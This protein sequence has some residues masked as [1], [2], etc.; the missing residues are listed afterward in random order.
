[1]MLH[2]YLVRHGQTEWN[3]GGRF[4]GQS[5][6]KLSEIGRKQ[7]Q[8]LTKYFPAHQLQAIYASTLERA[9]ETAN[10][11]AERYHA[12]VHLRDDLREMNFGDWEGLTFDEISKDWQNGGNEF[13]E[14]PEALMPPHGETFMEG[15]K[16]GIKALQDIMQ[17]HTGEMEEIAIVAHGAILRTLIAYV[18]HI[19]IQYVWR[20]RQGNTAISRLTIYDNNWMIDY[21]NNTSHLHLS[22]DTQAE[23]KDGVS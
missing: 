23:A 8:L 11:L 4:Q 7:A 10:I 12:P 3:V 15:Q 19:P 5:D 14:H 21:M 16:R 18:L 1:M 9:K 17:Q 6:I 2:I 20:M 22:A 13:F